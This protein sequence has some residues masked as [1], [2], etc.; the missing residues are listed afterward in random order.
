MKAALKKRTAPKEE[1][2]QQLIQATIRSVASVGLSDTTMAVVAREAG[3]SQGIINLHFQSKDRLLVETLNYIAD[4]YRV[5]WEKALRNAG[6]S[7][8]DKLAALVAMD[9]KPPVCDRNKLAVW[10]AFWGESKSRPVYRK[11]C[12]ARDA[13]CRKELVQV[14]E[15]LISLGGYKDLSAETVAA[16]LS[17]MTSGFWLD[18]LTNPRSMS[19]DQAMKICMSYLVTTFPR[20]F[21]G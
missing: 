8:A 5:T 21:R 13:A 17:A 12:A 16:C 9:F 3:L 7:P 15:E 10:F 6:D 18:L 4:E 14:C 2:Q 19:R 1:R 20:H 11:I